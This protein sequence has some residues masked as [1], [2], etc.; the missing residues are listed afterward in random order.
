MCNS[1]IS[2]QISHCFCKFWSWL[3]GQGTLSSALTLKAENTGIDDNTECFSTFG[4]APAP[5]KM[6]DVYSVVSE[7]SLSANVLL[8]GYVSLLR[9]FLIAGNDRSARSCIIERDSR[10]RP[11]ALACMQYSINSL[12]Q[13]LGSS[14]AGAGTRT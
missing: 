6:R 11:S 9:K 12:R 2:E 13:L 3:L 1:G 8:L 4:F 7:I 10:Q 5:E 14:T